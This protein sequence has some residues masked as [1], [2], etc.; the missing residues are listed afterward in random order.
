MNNKQIIIDYLNLKI[1]DDSIWVDYIIFL[2]KL[3]KEL[4]N[5][6]N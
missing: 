6:K 3:V 1:Q 4:E 2:K 5:E